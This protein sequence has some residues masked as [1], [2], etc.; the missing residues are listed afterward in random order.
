MRALR[1]LIAAAIFERVER[2]EK[3]RGESE[4]VDD[5]HWRQ[6]RFGG[7]GCQALM[8]RV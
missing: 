4:Y 7:D 5:H 2:G 8:P 3:E 6:R 1:A